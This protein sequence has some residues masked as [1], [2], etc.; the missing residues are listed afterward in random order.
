MSTAAQAR[1]EGRTRLLALQEGGVQF[2]R[3]REKNR[4]EREKGR[5]EGGET[6]G[7]RGRGR[8]L[9]LIHISEPTRRTPI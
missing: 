2:T 7:V 8:G 4:R 6:V 5:G 9:S 1:S 3:A